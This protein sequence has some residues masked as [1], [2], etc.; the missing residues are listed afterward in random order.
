MDLTDIFF[1]LSALLCLLISLGALALRG[2]G[3]SF[4]QG[5][6]ITRPPSSGIKKSG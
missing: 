4:M 2:V 3:F 5:A 1:F 6:A